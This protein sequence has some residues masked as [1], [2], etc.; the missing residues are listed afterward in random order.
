VSEE[1]PRVRNGPNISRG[2]T[3]SLQV[4]LCLV[5]EEWPRVRNGPG[6]EIKN[7]PSSLVEKNGADSPLILILRED[8]LSDLTDVSERLAQMIIVDILY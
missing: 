1:W 4:T 6:S 7:N 3:H 5:S 8:I 2:Q